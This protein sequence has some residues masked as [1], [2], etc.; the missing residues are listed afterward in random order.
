M[1]AENQE[2]RADHPIGG[3]SGCRE[4]H[5]PAPLSAAGSLHRPVP[6]VCRH[7]CD[8]VTATCMPLSSVI[9]AEHSV[10]ICLLT[11]L[12][13]CGHIAT[14][15]AAEAGC[16]SRH[17]PAASAA[18]APACL[19]ASEYAAIDNL[20]LQFGA[21]KRLC[22]LSAPFTGCELFVVCVSDSVAAF[23]Y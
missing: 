2:T 17:T 16:S 15:A 7:L 3:V 1:A 22:L 13:S 21:V 18:D 11:V 19:A 8:D 14:A 23:H 10:C 12:S 4:P 6:P 5:S 20:A 9:S